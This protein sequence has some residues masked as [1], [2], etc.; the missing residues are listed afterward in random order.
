MSDE[1]DDDVSP[2]SGRPDWATQYEQDK[3]DISQLTPVNLEE[4]W[5]DNDLIDN[6]SAHQEHEINRI[7]LR[8][9]HENDVIPTED[10]VSST[11]RGMTILSCLAGVLL[12]A[13]IWRIFL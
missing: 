13:I 6:L 5:A 10:E 12:I 3:I 1:R 8:W 4:V 9:K 11:L 2:F 7:L